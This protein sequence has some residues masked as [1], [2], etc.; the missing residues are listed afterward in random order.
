MIEKLFGSWPWYT[1]GTLRRVALFTASGAI[2]V[3][4][5]GSIYNASLAARSTGTN[6]YVIGVEL[7]DAGADA[8]AVEV[9]NRAAY[10]NPNDPYVFLELG[11]AFY[12]LGDSNNANLAWNQ[13]ARILPALQPK[14]HSQLQEGPAKSSANLEARERLLKEAQAEWGRNWSIFTGP[15]SRRPRETKAKPK[16][17]TVANPSP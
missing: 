5:F 8:D 6:L 16:A 10:L 3:M 13:A 4:I 11:N 15:W 7:A 9:L 2:V 12:R 1:V 14:T 17:E